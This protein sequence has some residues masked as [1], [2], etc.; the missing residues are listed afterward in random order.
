M[1]ILSP[2][3]CSSSWWFYFSSSDKDGNY[4]PRNNPIQD[5]LVG[6]ESALRL[7][8]VGSRRLH[9]WHWQYCKMHLTVTAKINSLCNLQAVIPL[10]KRTF[11]LTIIICC[12]YNLWDRDRLPWVLFCHPENFTLSFMEEIFNGEINDI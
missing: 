5:Q 6:S 1:P 3:I 4:R 12:S 9:N 8:V 11:S 10:R 2:A 7:Q